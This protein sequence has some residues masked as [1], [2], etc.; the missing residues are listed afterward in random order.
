MCS[1]GSISNN[2]ASTKIKY[3]PNYSTIQISKPKSSDSSL[4]TNRNLENTQT[5]PQCNTAAMKLVINT[6]WKE[7]DQRK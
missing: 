7:N 1:W 4:C 2:P 5:H 6:Y 3:F